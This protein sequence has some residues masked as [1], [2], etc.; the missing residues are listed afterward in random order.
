MSVNKCAPL[1]RGLA[2]L[3]LLSAAACSQVGPV[4]EVAPGNIEPDHLAFAM[5]EVEAL[6]AK[7][8]R[9]WCVPFARNLSGI[10]I[11]GDARTWFR[12][13]QKEE[14]FAV[15]HAPVVGAVMAFSATKSMP[16]GHVA[17]V[18][19]LVSDRE[20]LVDHAN[21]HRNEVSLGMRV[22]DVSK[23]NDWT[24]V[25][26]ESYPGAFGNVYPVDGFILPQAGDNDGRS[27][28]VEASLAQ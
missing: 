28:V 24:R 10:D 26:V 21:W 9:V 19:G 27:V 7:G 4:T 18:S 6:Q 2:L 12:Q 25:R 15:G 20:L 5:D 23:N 16:L 14:E 17:V 22:I 3:G 1:L 8:A 11:R 13:A